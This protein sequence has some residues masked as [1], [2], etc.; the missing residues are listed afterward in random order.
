M[1]TFSSYVHRWCRVPRKLSISHYGRGGRT[2]EVLIGEEIWCRV[3]D[4]DGDASRY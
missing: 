3:E 2:E 4:Y 1:G